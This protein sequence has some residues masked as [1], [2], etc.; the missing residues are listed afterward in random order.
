MRLLANRA[1]AEDVTQEV[2]LRAFERFG[3]LRE[4]PTAGG[5]LR[6]VA[7]N[8]SL[9]HLSRYRSR[10]TF[11]SELFSHRTEEDKRIPVEF[12]APDNVEENLRRRSGER[13]WRRR[14][15]GCRR[16]SVCRSFYFT[17]RD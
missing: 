5:W 2:F 10:W 1:E 16:H 3:D 4:S 9:N 14:S 15:R 7:T 11:F 17:W 12:A 8:L 13:W 6:T